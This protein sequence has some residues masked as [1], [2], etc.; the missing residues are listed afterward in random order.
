MESSFATVLIDLGFIILWGRILYI[1]VSRGIVTEIIKLTGLLAGIFF[2]FQ[3]YS[4]DGGK[5]NLSIPFLGKGY[6][7]LVTFLIIF[8]GIRTIFSL[9]GLIVNLLFKRQGIGVFER[10]ISFFAGSLRAA[11]FSSVIVFAFYLS[12]FNLSI[13]KRSLA[14]NIFAKPAAYTYM[15]ISRLF[16]VSD[17]KMKANQNIEEYLNFLNRQDKVKRGGLET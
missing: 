15:A 6:F 3:Y 17:K 10:W 7:N 12:P 8:F 11:L 9:L 5:L 13:A 16:P 2:A 14:I 1:A 4:S